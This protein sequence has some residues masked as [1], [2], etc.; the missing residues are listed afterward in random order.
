VVLLM[1]ASISS[2]G[3]DCDYFKVTWEEFD[4]YSAAY[5]AVNILVE[6]RKMV[7]WLDANP[8]RRPKK[9]QRFVVAW[10]SRSHARLLEAEVATM[11]KEDIRRS[12][13]PL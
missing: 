12:R 1:S 2:V 8:S 9:Y 11:V 13:V 7:C 4:K 6:M 5:P 10:L 3:F